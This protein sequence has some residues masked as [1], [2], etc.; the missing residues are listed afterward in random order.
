M[1]ARHERA[2]FSFSFEFSYTLLQ[3]HRYRKHRHRYNCCPSQP[4]SAS[5]T[6]RHVMLHD[7]KSMQKCRL[8]L[9]L[10]NAGVFACMP[11]ATGCCRHEASSPTQNRDRESCH[12]AAKIHRG[13]DRPA[14]T[15]FWNREWWSYLTSA[16]SPHLT[17]PCLTPA[18]RRVYSLSLAPAHRRTGQPAD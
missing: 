13:G 14:T 8:A 7:G 5:S 6:P 16:C 17:L 10:A 2:T 4:I 15:D 12:E 18:S 1:R 9:E 11:L 3:P